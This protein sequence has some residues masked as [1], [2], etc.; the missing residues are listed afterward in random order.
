MSIAN[1]DPSPAETETSAALP[2]GDMHAISPLSSPTRVTHSADVEKIEDEFVDRV[3]DNDDEELDLNDMRPITSIG[4]RALHRLAEVR[5]QQGVSLRN[6]AR[7]LGTDIK[8]I[9]HQEDA[10]TDLSL[11]TLYKWQMVLDVPI[12]DLLE[13]DQGSLSAPILMRAQLVRLMKTV[14][15]MKEKCES[16]SL[17]RM[18]QML[19]NQLLEIMPELKDVGPW[20]TVGQ[21]RTLDD[22]GRAA[23]QTVSEDV[24]RRRD[25]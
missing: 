25:H 10:Y 20:H 5:E 24:F 14:T 4:H 1:W 17:S 7:R 18:V 19:E 2:S 6:M 8:T 23:E 9:R 15:A 21:R 11:S 3:E 22:F 12:A 13:E 16:N